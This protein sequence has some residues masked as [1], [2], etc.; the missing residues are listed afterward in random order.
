MIPPSGRRKQF[1]ALR[2]LHFTRVLFRYEMPITID[3]LIASVLLPAGGRGGGIGLATSSTSTADLGHL[4]GAKLCRNPELPWTIALGR[5]E[6]SIK[7][8]VAHVVRIIMCD[9]RTDWLVQRIFSLLHPRRAFPIA[10]LDPRNV[11][12][13][14]LGGSP[15]RITVVPAEIDPVMTPGH[16][17]VSLENGSLLSTPLRITTL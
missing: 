6:T 8:R 4:C 1:S 11:A 14:S 3:A 5:D 17:V 9:A 10:G 16:T 12:L 15:S 2:L 13:G 7:H